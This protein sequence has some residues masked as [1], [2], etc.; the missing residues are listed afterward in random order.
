MLV[1]K[2]ITELQELLSTYQLQ[3]K[4][5]GFVPTMGALHQGHI[6]L[7]DVSKKQT[8]ITI[9][10]IFVNPTQFNNKED[11]TSYPRTP[12][13]DIQLLE[14]VNCDILYMPEKSDVY[15]EDIT[16]N[17]Q[18]GYLDTI[19]E[20]AKRPG[21]FNGVGQ[22]VSI[23]LEGIKP[24]KAFFGSKDYQQVMVVKNLVTQL[25]LPVEII[26]CPILREP[27]GLAMSSRNTRLSEEE[28]K[29]AAFIPKIMNEAKL[30]VAQK[31][32]TYAKLFVDEQIAKH[33]LMKLEYYEVCDADTLEILCNTHSSQKM[34]SLIALFVGNIRLIDNWMID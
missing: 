4:T 10:S 9:C 8:D 34:V 22:V 33:P 21:H 13:K 26:A 6:S 15:P 32:I 2:K 23:F 1:F 3:G 11:L 16:R 27:D 12:E 7:I 31:G 5:I 28:R 30:L 17:F 19:L 14:S 20:G 18:F 25:Q 24:H 29:T